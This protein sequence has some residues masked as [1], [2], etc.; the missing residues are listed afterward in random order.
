M[1]Y[2]VPNAS[3]NLLVSKSNESPIFCF[4]VFFLTLILRR[5][6]QIY[7]NKNSATS[8]CHLETL[9]VLSHV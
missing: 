9:I 1:D 7:I 4:I 2:A 3:L 8:T 6:V 5:F